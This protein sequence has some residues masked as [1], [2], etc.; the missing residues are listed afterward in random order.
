MCAEGGIG[1]REGSF[2]F[3]RNFRLSFRAVWLDS[4]IKLTDL[5]VPS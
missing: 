5:R 3:V 2:D 4:Q 1:V